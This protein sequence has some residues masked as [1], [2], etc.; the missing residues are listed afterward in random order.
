MIA[1]ITRAYTRYYS[2][3]RSTMAYV[4]WIDHKG[5]CGCT[6][7]DA[8]QYNRVPIGDHMYALFE[9]AKREGV[10]IEKETW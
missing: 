2:D 4:E 8:R 1:K 9:R 3:N 6:E 10:T 5:K 7:G